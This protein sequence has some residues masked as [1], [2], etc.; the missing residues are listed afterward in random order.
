MTRMT[1]HTT[2]ESN[3]IKEFRRTTDNLMESIDEL[4]RA[5]IKKHKYD[6][7]LMEKLR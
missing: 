5:L 7:N 4:E 2:K 6:V 1:N 3:F